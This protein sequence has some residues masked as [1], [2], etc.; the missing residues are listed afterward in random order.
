MKLIGSNDCK[1]L[2]EVILSQTSS[3]VHLLGV[4]HVMKNLENWL[5]DSS[6][7]SNVHLSITE[8]V[9]GKSSLVSFQSDSEFYEMLQNV[10]KKWGD[11]EK[12]YIKDSK[13][14]FLDY[15]IKNK[16]EKIKSKLTA[17]RNTRMYHD[18]SKALNDEGI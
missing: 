1:E 18:A 3:T 4:E 7:P 15:S 2:C 12:E 9:V 11:I 8:V 14:K 10:M 5:R 16:A 6:L 13:S 17:T